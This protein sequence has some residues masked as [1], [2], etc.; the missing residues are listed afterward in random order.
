MMVLEEILIQAK[1]LNFLG[2]PPVQD[3]ILN[4]NGFV[5]TINELNIGLKEAKLVD[6][7]SGGGVPALILIENFNKWNFV[8]I[9]RKEKRAEFLSWAVKKLNAGARTEI[10][11]DEVENI[12]R[13][14]QYEA[15]INFVTARSFGPPP[16][17]AECACRFLKNKGYLIVSEPPNGIDR[18]VNPALNETGLVPFKAN[19]QENGTFQVLELQGKPS[20]RLPRRPGVPKKRPLW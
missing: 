12:A 5:K 10:I 18:W 8:L 9:E 4:A 16:I 6:L 11:C 3:H 2:K 19:K 15:T 17:T 13:N 7:G 20:N 14:P 1:K